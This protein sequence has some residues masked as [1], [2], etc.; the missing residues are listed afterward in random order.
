MR[1]RIIPVGGQDSP[2]DEEQGWLDLEQLATVEIT[3][4]EAEHP[5]ESAL[6]TDA[7]P[8]WRAEQPGIQSIRLLFD[9]PRKISRIQL[10]F[11]EQERERTQEFVLRWSPRGET[12]AR[13]I[14]RQ[15]YSFSPPG[16]GREVE[17]YTVE[18]DALKMLELTIIPDIS[19]GEARASLARLRLA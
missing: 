8:G 15:Q 7:G 5:I 14:V 9:Q 10:V 3:S 1:K 13:D 19:G 16:S 6:S 17:D 18:L 11:E 2:P 12:G 4:E